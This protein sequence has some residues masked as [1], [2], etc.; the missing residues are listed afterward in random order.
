MRYLLLAACLA[1]GLLGRAQ[2]PTLSGDLK[3]WHTTTL[4]FEGPNTSEAD[5]VNPFADY[6]MEV[7]FY[8]ENSRYQ[9]PGYYAADGNAGESG[10]EAGNKWRVH[11]T[12]D[13]EGTWYWQASFRTGPNVAVSEAMDEGEPLAFNGAKGSFKIEAS[14]KLAPDFRS[15]GRLDYV[16]Q[17]YLQFAGSKAYFLKGGADAPEVFLAYKEIDGTYAHDGKEKWMK[18]WQP[19]EQDWQPGDPTWKDGKGKGIIGALNY[20]ASKKMNAV[21]FLTMNVEGDGKNVWPWTSDHDFEHFDC[22]KLDQW[23]LIFA[24]AQQLGLY[25]HFKTQETENDQLLDGGQLGFH[26]KL[27]YR[28]LIARFGHHL[29]LNWNLGEENTQTDAQ[30]KAMAGFFHRYDPY[31]HHIVI[32]TY[33]GQQNEVYT[34]LLG[35]ASHLTGISLQTGFGFVHDHTLEWITASTAAGQ[36]WVVANDEQNGANTGVTPEADYPGM[37]GRPDNHDDIR[38]HTLWGNLMAGGA[39]VEYYFG[40]KYPESDLACNDWRS[41]DQMWDYTHYA[42]AFFN[43]Y[44]PFHEMV[45]Q[46]QLID[47]PGYCFAKPGSI[48][49]VYLPEAEGKIKLDLSGFGGQSFYVAWYNPR[50]GGALVAGSLASIKGGGKTMLGNPPLQTNEDWVALISTEKIL[51][52]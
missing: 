2:Q 29:A 45:A 23:E 18:H 33:P 49:A 43:D 36:P 39:G 38:H 46:D 22:S 40:Y 28:E 3:L 32:H 50:S 34:P 35:D 24:H 1:W 48:Y 9:V 27:Y 42:L 37:D 47:Q 17:R 20:L 10:A 13:N 14:D 52:K 19:H 25:L 21:S 7:T 8:Q 5:Q 16:G 6:R 12:P 30:R 31:H 15:Q 26:R 51:G 4:T 11:F 41:R 44:L